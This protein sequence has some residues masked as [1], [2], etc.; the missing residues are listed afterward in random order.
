MKHNVLRSAALAL[1]C[2]FGAAT[3]SAQTSG[4]TIVSGSH[5]LD[6][7]GTVVTSAT[8][9]FQ[10]V[11]AAGVPISFRA[12]GAGGQ[13]IAN[14]V[15]TTVTSGA[16][17]IQLAD[18]SLTSPLNVCYSVTLISNLTGR[19]IPFPGYSCI[20]PSGSSWNFDTYT[21]NLGNLVLEQYGIPGINANL[22][23]DPNFLSGF[24][25]WSQPGGWTIANG[26]PYAGLN[27][28]VV[29][30]SASGTSFWSTSSTFFLTVGQTYVLSGYIN[31]TG[32]SGSTDPSWAIVNPGLTTIYAAI[33][34]AP[35]VASSGISTFTFSPSG[36]SAGALLPVVLF[37]TT[38]GATFTSLSASNP[39]VEL[40]VQGLTGPTGA[41]GPA[42]PATIAIGTVT[43]LAS[44]A[45]PTVTNSGSSSNMVLNFGIPAGT[46][47][48]S[49]TFSFSVNGTVITTSATTFTVNGATI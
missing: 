33:Y 22:V 2:A 5:L 20:Q 42:G 26:S 24:T 43:A 40:A 18:T 13:A 36:Y 35:G 44:G 7:T 11:N 45:T 15:S 9:R 10:P 31:A 4:Y 14:P 8:I 23:Q 28:L 3:A 47:S 37:F 30:V 1:L 48:G 27:S 6:A 49:G 21:P 17:S 19:Q 46:S 16:F 38:R 34:V 25:Y 32:V 29:P 39:S 41:T 12:G